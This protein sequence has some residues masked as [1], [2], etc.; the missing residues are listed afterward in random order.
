MEGNKRKVIT[1]IKCSKPQSTYS[2][3][4]EHC[5]VCKPKCPEKHTFHAVVAQQ[6]KDARK[7]EVTALG[8]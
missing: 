2:S 3:N 6:K 5:H 7:A 8:L 4:R 1:C